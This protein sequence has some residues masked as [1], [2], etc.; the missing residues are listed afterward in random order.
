MLNDLIPEK[1][2]QYALFSP[3]S[4]DEIARKRMLLLDNINQRFGPETLTLASE[5]H[6][7]WQMYQQHLSPAYTTR[8]NEILR[9][10]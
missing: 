1:H 5:P 4:Y 6:K 9:V 3:A 10:R 7:R 8:W 2:Q